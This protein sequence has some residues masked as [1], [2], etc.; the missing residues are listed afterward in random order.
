MR[1]GD[2]G[3]MSHLKSNDTDAVKKLL[4]M[5]FV[6]GRPVKLDSWESAESP[7]VVM[8]GDNTVALEPELAP[9]V[10]VTAGIN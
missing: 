3:K 2:S 8:I 9:M 10:F 4:N 6:P 7:L 5:G 1:I